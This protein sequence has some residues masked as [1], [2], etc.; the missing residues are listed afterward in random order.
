M[1]WLRSVL[2]NTLFYGTTAV[3]ALICAPLLAAPRD[4]V[5]WLARAWAWLEL[6]LL[7]CTAGLDTRFEGTPPQGPAILAVKHQSAWETILMG[8]LARDFA[9]VVKREL[10]W[11]PL[12]GW[13]LARTGAIPVDRGAGASALRDLL[14]RGRAASRQNRVIVIF[15][16]GTRTTPGDTRPYHPGIAALYAALD[17]PVIPVALNSGWFWPRRSFLR[18]PGRITIRYLPAIPPGLTRRDFQHRLASELEAGVAALAPVHAP[19][20]SAPGKAYT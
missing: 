1:L 3:F 8:L 11:I 5:L 17:L 9:V 16:E 4:S 14:R 15:P 6:W 10:L 7:R 2:F 13:F 20:G 12:Y 19:H 18:R